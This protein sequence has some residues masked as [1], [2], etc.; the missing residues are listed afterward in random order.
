MK[1][2]DDTINLRNIASKQSPVYLLLAGVALLVLL[3]TSF[4]ASTSSGLEFEQ[5]ASDIVSGLDQSVG[6]IL[7][8]FD[9]LSSILAVIIIS[10]VL[11]F[12]RRW[13]LSMEV[14]L[15]GFGA[16][17]I[18]FFLY[19]NTNSA[20]AFAVV[21]TIGAFVSS[22]TSTIA[23]LFAALV[24]LSQL[25]V[26]TN[27]PLDVLAGIAL[28]VFVG[29]IIRFF[30]GSPNYSR[31]E[32]HVRAAL[33]SAK[34]DVAELKHPKVD[35]R[36]ST[37]YFVTTQTGDKLFAKIITAENRIADLMF[38]LWR[39][40][41]YK[42][43]EDETPFLTAKQALEHE[44]YVTLLAKSKGVE[45]PNIRYVISVNRNFAVL[46]MDQLEGK[47]LDSVPKTQ[48]TDKLIKQIWTLVQ[49]LHDAQIAHRDLRLANI[50][51]LSNGKPMLIDFSFGETFAS[52]KR[53]VMDRVELLVSF[54]ILIGAKKAVSIAN[55]VIGPSM[56]V[57]IAPYLQLDALAGSTTTAVKGNPKILDSIR[58]E[59][60]KVTGSDLSEPYNLKRLKLTIGWGVFALAALIFWALFLIG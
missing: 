53:I 11:L 41:V 10:I 44:A 49:S 32:S 45:V 47:S 4:V 5:K 12:I 2:A 21:T 36:G 48:I 6:P 54:S 14:F 1:K 52:H 8:F 24:G 34:I 51:V 18:S 7:L 15:A 56:L 31:S 23:W 58:K 29:S 40:F 50:F 25:Y 3:F 59:I 46:A 35:A 60:A 33:E 43:F 13:R 19:A 27:T 17:L 28:G 16:L 37:P 22:R 55:S 9:A 39:S 26:E 30:F 42:D 38:K 57:E 20:I